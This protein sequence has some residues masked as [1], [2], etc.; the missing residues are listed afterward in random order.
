M[1]EKNVPF[2]KKYIIFSGTFC[3]SYDLS[4]ISKAA[5]IL[6]EKGYTDYH[7][8]I[9]GRGNLPKN[10]LEEI[11]NSSEISFLGWLNKKE[12]NFCLNNSYAGLAPY[13]KEALMS[14]PNKFFEYLAYGL[15]IISSLKSEMEV[16][17]KQRKLGFNYYSQSPESLASA[18]IKLDNNFKS[19]SSRNSILKEFE[20]NFN[21]DIIYFKFAEFVKRTFNKN[22]KS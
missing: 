12:L 3:E 1:I 5:R 6:K 22:S 14:M 10:I 4:P 17:I 8:L 7:F 13:S 15:P 21:G 18:I 9:A 16:L 20:N 2:K 19:K 11:K